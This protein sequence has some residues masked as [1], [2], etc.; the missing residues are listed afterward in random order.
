MCLFT[1]V[2]CP[3]VSEAENGILSGHD[4]SFMDRVSLQC[5]SGHILDGPS[6]VMCKANGNWSAPLGHC[7]KLPAESTDSK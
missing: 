5:Y 1:E 7:R 4:N 3:K 6:S 2:R